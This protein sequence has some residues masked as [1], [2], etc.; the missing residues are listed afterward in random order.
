VTQ[1]PK[2]SKPTAIKDILE[3]TL[4]LIKKPAAAQLMD[5]SH[6]WSQLLG[7]TISQ[8]TE[9]VFLRNGVLTINTKSSSWNQELQLLKNQILQK[10]QD[11][12]PSLQVKELRFQ[13]RGRIQKLRKSKG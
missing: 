6:A 2:S 13:S 4:K 1:H 3:Q 10:I 11:Q 12:F 9:P 7:P 8:K 5:L